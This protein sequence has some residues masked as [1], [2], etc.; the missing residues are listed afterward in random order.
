MIFCRY[1]QRK[2]C[3][4]DKDADTAAALLEEIGE[5]SSVTVFDNPS[6]FINIID[7]KLTFDTDTNCQS[8]RSLSM[9]KNCNTAATIDVKKITESPAKVAMIPARK[10]NKKAGAVIALK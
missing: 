2:I 6:D 4:D 7:P 9:I 3:F 8:L 5:R 10:G 1:C